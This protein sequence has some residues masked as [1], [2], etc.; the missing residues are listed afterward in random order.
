MTT[1]QKA[2]EIVTAL[3]DAGHLLEAMPANLWWKRRADCEQIVRRILE[4][5]PEPEDVD[6]MTGERTS[7]YKT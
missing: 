2:S 3:I 4:D 6:T 5:A 7:R 1:S